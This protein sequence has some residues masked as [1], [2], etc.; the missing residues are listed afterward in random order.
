MAACTAA[1]LTQVS[2]NQPTKESEATTANAAMAADTFKYEADRFAD[3]A[4]L[5]YKV[6]G[7][8]QLTDQQRELVYYLSEAA[9][10]GRDILWDQNYRHNLRIRKVLEQILEHYQG[11]REGKDWQAFEAYA[12]RV[13]FSNGIHHHYST[14]KLEPGFGADY[15]TTLIN[16]CSKDAQWPLCEGE[17]PKELITFLSPI[18]FDPSVDAKR[19]NL[20]DGADHI[21]QSA[22]NFYFGLN[23]AEVEAYYN[24]A[25]KAAPDDKISWG[26]NSQ[27]AKLPD[28]SIR[29]RVWKADGLYGPAIKQMISWL[30]KAVTVAENEAQKKALQ[31]LVKYYETGDLKVWDQYNIAWVNDTAS[32]VDVTHGFIEVYGDPLGMRGTYEAVVSIKDMEATKRI[33]TIGGAAQW[34]EDNSPIA[35][36]FKKKKVTGISAKVI[37]VVQESGDAAPATPIGINLPNASWIREQHGSKSVSLGNIVDA[38]D[39]V[40]SGGGVLEEF[41]HDEEEVK[42][43]KK[44]GVLAGHLHTDMHEVIGHASGQLKP[45]ITKEMLQNYGSTLEEARADLVALYY[46]ADKKLVDLGVMPSLEVGMAAYDNYIRNGLMT[47]LNRLEMG[48]NLEEAHMRNRQLVAAWVFER[49]F[50]KGHIESVKRDGKTFYKIRSYEETRKLF[51][52]LLAEIQRIISTGDYKAGKELVEK[53]GVKVDQQVLKE[54]RDRYAKLNTPPYMG[55]IQPELTLGSGNKVNIAYPTNFLQQHLDLGKRYGLLPWNN[56]PAAD[57]ECTKKIARK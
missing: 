16:G 49:A 31:L 30:N 34:F 47:Q 8:D 38:Y 57:Q 7:W 51:G 4:V 18:L 10:S 5:R 13:F 22:T 1:I 46:M 40:K 36:E 54:V 37:T 52:E 6:P 25:K 14:K 26:L 28:G 27:L 55:F 17:S 53:Y 19:V 29:E 2:C 32:V 12:K 39:I 33:A 42:R 9:R 23:K 41:C 35:T 50:K 11:P 43:A 21:A 44:W 24:K 15:L 48:D 45:G 3:L 20:D 56:S